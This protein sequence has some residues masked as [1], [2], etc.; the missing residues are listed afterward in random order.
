M[1]ST[2]D[3]PLGTG[4]YK[5]GKFEVNRFIEFEPCQGLVGRRPAG[6]PRQLQFRYGA[7]RIL[8]RPRRRVRGL[9][10]H[11][12]ICSARNSPRASGLRA[13]ISRRSRTAASSASSCRTKRRPARRAGS[14]IPAATSSRIRACARRWIYAFDFEWTNKTI[15][16]GAYARTLSPFQNSDMMAMGR[17]RRKSLRCL[18]RSAARCRTRCSASRSCRRCRTAR[19]RTGRCCARPRSCFRRQV[20]RV[21]DGKR[22]CRTAKSSAIEFLLTSR[23]SSRTTCPFIKNLGTLGIEATLRLVDPVQYPRAARRFRFRHDD[24]TLQHVGDA[25]RLACGR[26][27]PRRRPATKGSYN[28][29]GIA[30]PAHRCPDRAGSSAPTP[31]PS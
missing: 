24:R 13:T 15:M 4:P 23:R 27:S 10:R 18:S 1:K 19:D 2:L 30:D 22:C 25:R 7:L 17:R 6:L 21:K 5:V 11:R 8:S 12:T 3:I 29:A 31:A 26:S 16:Y 20:C 9:Y 14:S 28:L